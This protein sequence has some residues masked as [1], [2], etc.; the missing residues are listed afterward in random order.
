MSLDDFVRLTPDEFEAVA[1]R[2]SER[3]EERRRDGWEQARIVAKMAISPYLKQD[4]SLE[5]FM[6]LPWDERRRKAKILSKEE[7]RKRMEEIV[8]RVRGGG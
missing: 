3:E 2:I 5:Q 8:K 7:D 4:M 6:P 1:A